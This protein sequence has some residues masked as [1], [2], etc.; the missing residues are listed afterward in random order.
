MVKRNKKRFPE[1]FCFQLSE[2]ESLRCQNGISKDND[3]DGRGGRRYMP[4]AFM[5]HGKTNF[6]G[7][8]ERLEKSYVDK[9]EKNMKRW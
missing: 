4:Y 7:W 6:F 8:W 5:E 9:F 3:P 2:E 1:D